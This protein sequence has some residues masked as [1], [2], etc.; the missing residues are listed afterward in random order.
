MV[1]DVAHVYGDK[2]DALIQGPLEVLSLGE[3]VIRLQ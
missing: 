3:F 1:M 2:R